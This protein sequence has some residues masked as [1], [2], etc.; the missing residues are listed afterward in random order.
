MTAS[1]GNK[2]GTQDMKGG[3]LSGV[4]WNLK[5]SGYSQ[6][7]FLPLCAIDL[8]AVSAVRELFR[9]FIQIR[10]LCQAAVPAIESF[11]ENSASS[12]VGDAERVQ[13]CF[14]EESEKSAQWVSYQPA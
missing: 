7:S 14:H 10:S 8:V 3:F 9:I 2:H 11:R 13:Q 6:E 1:I 5:Y 12:G 4:H